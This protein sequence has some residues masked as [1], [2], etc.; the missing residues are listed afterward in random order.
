MIYVIDFT[1][2]ADTPADLPVS[3]SITV[4]GDYITQV[5][6]LIPPGHTALAGLRLYYGNKQLIPANEGEWLK[7]DGEILVWDEWIEIPG[8]EDKFILKGYNL[9]DTYDHTFYVRIV[10]TYKKYIM[11]SDVMRRFYSLFEKL[12]YRIMGRM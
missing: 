6:I 7:G 12:L 5:N 1:V 3:Q 4:R 10:T 8:G 11:P 9:D 2:P